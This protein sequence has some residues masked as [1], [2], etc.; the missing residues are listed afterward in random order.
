MHY[1]HVDKFYA[2]KAEYLQLHSNQIMGPWSLGTMTDIT[3]MKSNHTNSLT[4]YV[5]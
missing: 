2:R 5:N 1:L 4:S 3:I